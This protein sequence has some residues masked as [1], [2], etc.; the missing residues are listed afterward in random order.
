MKLFSAIIAAAVVI[1]SALWAIARVND[2]ERS[3]QFY[4]RSILAEWGAAKEAG[5]GYSDLT[6][7][8]L[9]FGRAVKRAQARVLDLQ[10]ELLVI[11]ENKP[12]GLP[13]S[14]QDRKDRDYIKQEIAKQTP[15][16]SLSQ[17]HEDTRRAQRKLEAPTPTEQPAATKQDGTRV[18][19]VEPDTSMKPRT[20]TTPQ[21]NRY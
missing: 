16:T 2:W 14:E 21:I 4:Q 6:D 12:F 1:I 20:T 17:L 10:R 9:A 3:K 19:D 7:A 15:N 18:L 11:Y 13:L 5:R 8:A